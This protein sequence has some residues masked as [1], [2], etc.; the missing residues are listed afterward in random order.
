MRPTGTTGRKPRATLV[1]VLAGMMILVG[2]VIGATPASA[3]VDTVSGSATPLFIGGLA[4]LGAPAT[5][6]GSATEPVD[7]YGPI[8]SGLL[9]G[10][11]CPTAPTPGVVVPLVISVGLL[12]ACTRGA[13]VVNAGHLAFSESRAAVADVQLGTTNLGVVTG[14][15]RAD[16]NGA[17][18]ST[19]IVGTSGLPQNPL[20]NTVPS[21]LPPGLVSLVL[22]EQIV[23]NTLGTATITVRAVH[24]TLLGAIDIIIGEATCSALGPDVNAGS[25]QVNKV[26]P[27]DAQTTV[28]T[29]TITCP[30][31]AGSPFVRT[32]TGT[33]SILIENLAAG[34]VCTAVES[35]TPGF[36]D[37]PSQTFPPVVIG[38]TQNL[39]FTN[40]R[41]PP[42]GTGTVIVNKTAPADAQTTVFTFTITCSG[43]GAPFTRTITG[44]GTA[45][46]TG[47]PVG[48]V[49]TVAESPIAGFVNQPSQT[50]AALLSG[51]SQTA[52]FVNVREG[53]VGTVAISKVAPADAQG[54]TFT[55][56]ITC[57][58]VVGSPFTRTVTGT[59]ATSVTGVPAGS[60]CTVV[61][62]PSA[63]FV[64][65]PAQTTPP[66]VAGAIHTLSFTNVRTVSGTGSVVVNKVAPADAQGVTF[67]FTITCGGVAGS[68]FTRTITGSGSAAVTGLPPGTI[69]V[70]SET[71]L[72][73]FVVQP[74]QNFPVVSVGSTEQVTFVNT[75]VVDPGPGPGPGPG[76]I[77]NNNNNLNNNNNSN[78]N[79]NNNTVNVGGDTIN[80]TTP[81]GHITFLGGTPGGQGQGQN[82]GQSQSQDQGQ[83]QGQHLRIAST[84]GG[85]L[86][87]TGSTLL[88]MMVL[89][90][91]ALV[92]GNLMRIGSRGVAAEGAPSQL[93]QRFPTVGAAPLEWGPAQIGRA[94]LAATVALIAGVARLFSRRR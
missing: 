36:V 64:T 94:M 90:F 69:C 30:G 61:E 38:Q 76:G 16:G 31:A 44:T 57:P 53:G 35:P 65:L 75:R 23:T 25:V 84:P 34:T 54:V 60:V 5:V 37:Q 58:G 52:T 1:A 46:V 9:G 40:T 68:P 4:P 48:S 66:V 81:P 12:E 86:A 91:L 71:P 3:D 32:V 89:A 72:S 93:A 63:E 55:F 77:T 13:G 21:I 70:A 88:P 49:C 27:A 83:Q 87:R 14:E 78:T 45:S 2:L 26:A 82:Q 43:V 28:F 15:C 51:G 85:I 33:G 19:T 18:G 39:T 41:V 24:A 79:N 8:G 47:L 7:A 73:G 20:P 42:P 56:T 6:S 92:L 17:V 22:N 11:Q 67:T 74:N 29:F 62:T 50:L 59:N 10:A 80:I